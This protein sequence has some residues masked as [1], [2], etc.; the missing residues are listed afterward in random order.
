[1]L[2]LKWRVVGL[3]F[4]CVKDIH[5]II[6]P[7]A[8]CSNIRDQPSRF[9]FFSPEV[10]NGSES[11][12]VR[13]MAMKSNDTCRENN[14]REG[15]AEAWRPS[16]SPGDVGSTSSAARHGGL[17]RLSSRSGE[18]DAPL[19]WCSSRSPGTWWFAISYP[20]GRERGA[21]PLS[22]G[23]APPPRHQASSCVVS[24]I[25]VHEAWHFFSFRDIA[26]HCFKWNRGL[27]GLL[28]GAGPNEPECYDS[29]TRV[30][31]R[32]TASPLSGKPRDSLAI[33]R[34]QMIDN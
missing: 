12:W 27:R 5:K 30:A 16:S 31:A 8:I 14:R 13:W 3:R 7:K 19:S 24:S 21:S 34:P 10:V 22:S 20:D 28:A 26:R 25:R 6:W 29:A 11:I 9:L 17:C 32:R 18:G 15:R 2:Q 1:M 23:K 33:G 4:S